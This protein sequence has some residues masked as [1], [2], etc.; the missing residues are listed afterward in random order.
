MLAREGSQETRM[1]DFRKLEVWNKAHDVAL[2]VYCV[3]AAFPKAE[4]YGITSQ[5]RR[6]AAS[7]PANIAE[8]CGR[9]TNA[10]FARFLTIASGSASELD[11][12]VLLARDLGYLSDA[13]HDQLLDGINHVRRMLTSLLSRVEERRKGASASG[14]DRAHRLHES[15]TTK[16]E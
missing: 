15:R 16:H 5:M 11:Y 9:G 8:G 1:Q 3:T 2:S 7:I 6:C 14:T 4:I 10:D 13:E 12:F